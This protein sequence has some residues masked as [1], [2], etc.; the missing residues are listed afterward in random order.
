MDS[1]SSQPADLHLR[2][3]RNIDFNSD[4]LRSLVDGTHNH[5]KVDSCALNIFC[6]VVQCNYDPNA[7]FYVFSSWLGPLVQG[8]II[9]TRVI[10]TFEENIRR[11]CA[12]PE[13][14]ATELTQRRYWCIPLCGGRP[15]HWVLAIIDREQS[16]LAIYDSLPELNSR[17]WA[18]PVCLK[19]SES[20]DRDERLPSTPQ[21]KLPEAIDSSTSEASPDKEPPPLPSSILSPDN[22]LSIQKVLDTRKGHQSRTGVRSERS[23]KLDPKF[24]KSAID[25][26]FASTV[27]QTESGVAE[28]R[29]SAMKIQ[30]ASHRV[31]IAQALDLSAAAIPVKKPR[32]L[33]WQD[34][35]QKLKSITSAKV[36]PNILE[37]NVTISHPLVIGSFIIIRNKIDKN[38]GR[39]YIGEVLDIYQKGSSSRYGSIESA[40][41]TSALSFI[42]VRAY[43][44]LTLK[45]G[46]F[47]AR[48]EGE[49]D[50]DFDEKSKS[51]TPAALTPTF[52]CHHPGQMTELHAHVKVAHLVYNLGL[53]ALAKDD[54]GAMRLTP[55]AEKRW[56][57]LTASKVA[58]NIIR[59]V[60]TIR[61]PGK[62]VA[63]EG[64]LNIGQSL[65]E[66]ERSQTSSILQHLRLMIEASHLCL[67][68]TLENIASCY[69]Q[70]LLSTSQA[71]PRSGYRWSSVIRDNREDIDS[72]GKKGKSTSLLLGVWYLTSGGQEFSISSTRITDLAITIMLAHLFALVA[73]LVALPLSSA[74]PAEAR[75]NAMRFEERY[76][77]ALPPAFKERHLTGLPPA[78]EERHLTALPP[79][80]ARSPPFRPAAPTIC[81]CYTAIEY[82]TFEQPDAEAC[83]KPTFGFI[84]PPCHLSSFP[85]PSCIHDREYYGLSGYHDIT[86]SCITVSLLRSPARALLGYV[87]TAQTQLLRILL[88]ICVPSA[89]PLGV[90]QSL[91]LRDPARTYPDPY[92]PV[93]VRVPG[94]KANPDSI[95]AAD[96]RDSKWTRGHSD[97]QLPCWRSFA[98]ISRDMTGSPACGYPP[99]SDQQ[100]E[101]LKVP[102]TEPTY[103]CLPSWNWRSR[104]V[105][106]LEA[107]SSRFGIDIGFDSRSTRIV[108]VRPLIADTTMFA[109]TR[110]RVAVIVLLA[111]LRLAG[112]TSSETGHF[113]TEPLLGIPEGATMTAAQ[114][115]PAP[116]RARD[117]REF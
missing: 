99:S 113:F 103:I 9:N 39:I 102:G 86:A 33:R 43:L 105:V 37:K 81:T 93:G 64:L 69:T 70:K 83:S 31:R 98:D 36:V 62:L 77:T 56:L 52:S 6:A 111:A 25:P 21:L 38:E 24:H 22:S 74:L 48:D 2:R 29:R 63:R 5:Q 47:I 20:H 95:P 30:E 100:L 61:I 23:V 50:S 91:N 110:V 28:L 17:I 116:Q 67:T 7:D 72:H 75:Y 117:P 94:A 4:D 27:E 46:R 90:L 65:A 13:S 1:L 59:T 55:N 78:F 88:F 68:L 14:A 41:T 71:N 34:A 92:A 97:L 42:S 115:I 82:W 84:S 112:A 54:Y 89:C 66:R 58:G 87:A 44:P 73:L 3:I 96:R 35:A 49:Y 10:G 101:H 51:T 32:E 107:R 40:K 8:L 12:D 108:T 109:L 85:V 57:A 26:S 106:G 16:M 104:S 114:H 60:L 76:I 11:A 18:R 15:Y 79:A 53:Y 45:Q 80:L 19:L